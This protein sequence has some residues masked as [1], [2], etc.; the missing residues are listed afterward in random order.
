M[1]KFEDILANAG[2]SLMD[3][4]PNNSLSLIAVLNADLA[5]PKN[6]KKYVRNITSPESLL[7]DKSTRWTILKLLPSENATE[8]CQLLGYNDN[9]PYNFLQSNSHNYYI[10][11]TILF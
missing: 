10:K 3:L 7:L 6:I 9:D 4:L 1:Y 5:N 2:Q 11:F 8:L